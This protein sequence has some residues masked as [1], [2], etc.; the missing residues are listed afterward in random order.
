[1]LA[2]I[3]R[4]GTGR[5]EFSAGWRHARAVSVLRSLERQLQP[6][7][8]VRDPE[9]VARAGLSRVA[10]GAD[11]VE[12]AT[13]ALRAG[14]DHGGAVR[15]ESC[16]RAVRLRPRP[17]TRTDRLGGGGT[18]TG[19]WKNLFVHAGERIAMDRSGGAIAGRAAGVCGDEC[20]AEVR[21]ECVL[22][23]LSFP[24]SV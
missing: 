22:Y 10:D 21:S 16:R 14:A 20:G 3:L 5:V 18:G 12:V 11:A 24:A 1:R 19:V 13:V 2:G 6:H 8:G 23:L 15:T 9:P 7:A 4:Q 17:V